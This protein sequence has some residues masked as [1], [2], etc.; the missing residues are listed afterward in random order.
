[1]AGLRRLLGIPRVKNP[2]PTL[3]PDFLYLVP[4]LIGFGANI[5]TTY[6]TEV[7]KFT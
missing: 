3:Y 1:M 6:A 2:V 5:P 4:I 7:V